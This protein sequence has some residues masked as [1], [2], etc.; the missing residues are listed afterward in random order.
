MKKKC[1]KTRA[2]TEGTAAQTAGGSGTATMG[3]E[4]REGKADG[5]CNTRRDYPEGRR[6]DRDVDSGDTHRENPNGA[7]ESIHGGVVPALTRTA[8]DTAPDDAVFRDIVTK[9]AEGDINY[10]KLYLKYIDLIS[11]KMVDEDEVIY[12]ATFIDDEDQG[13]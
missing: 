10:Q 11:G 3:R 9:A 6:P 4:E 12:E 7:E 1:T 13:T 2:G 8:V 5:P